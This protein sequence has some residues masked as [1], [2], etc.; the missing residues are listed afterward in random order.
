MYDRDDGRS[1]ME[2]NGE[3]QSEMIC[4]I[5]EGCIDESKGVGVVLKGLAWEM[6]VCGQCLINMGRTEEDNDVR[7]DEEATPT[8]SGILEDCSQT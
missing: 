5:C 2:I 3:Y 4:D 7:N 1:R 6:N 8:T